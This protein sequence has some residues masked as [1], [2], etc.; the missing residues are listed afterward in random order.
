M[1]RE[2]AAV[3][4]NKGIS[5]LHSS[6]RVAVNQSGKEVYDYHSMAD[7]TRGVRYPPRAGTFTSVAKMAQKAHDVP[8]V[9]LRQ[10]VSDQ[11][12][13]ALSTQYNPSPPDARYGGSTGRQL[14]AKQLQSLSNQ[15]DQSNVSKYYASQMNDRNDATGGLNLR[16]ALGDP[17]SALQNEADQYPPNIV[18]DPENRDEMSL[19][20]RKRQGVASPGSPPKIVKEFE[21][22]RRVMRKEAPDPNVFWKV[23]PPEGDQ[24]T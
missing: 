22:Q 17:N 9:D 14:D 11:S 7:P 23:R 16:Q 21:K 3:V 20:K 5:P 19:I 24:F 6:P 2:R 10:K 1:A 8:S 4:D 13:R 12:P 18:T 15:I